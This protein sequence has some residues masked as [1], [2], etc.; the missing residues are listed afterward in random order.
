MQ[1]ADADV[2]GSALHEPAVQVLGFGW[3]PRLQL[4][5]KRVSVRRLDVLLLSV[6]IA[7]LALHATVDSFLAPEPGTGP[8][9]HLVRGFVSLAVLALAAAICTRLPAGGRAAVAAA[10]GLLA[11][12]G[13]ALAIADAR[14]V[15]ARGEDWTG[16]L[17]LPVGLLLCAY[18][19]VLLWRS[20]KP[21]R[22][23]YMRR[24]GIA[25]AAALLAYWL[26]LPLAI[27]ILATHR[28][29]AA[30]EP[31]DLG[32]TYEEVTLRTTDGLEL[33]A[34][35]VASRNGAAVISY[36][37]RRGKLDQA[38]MLARHGYGVLLV[39]ARGYDGSEG[40]P[41]VFGWD[42]AKDINAAVAW[43]RRR[44][45]VRDGRIGGIGFSVGGEMML[46]AAASNPE[47][48][49]VVSEGAGVRSVRDHLLRGPRGLFSLPEA[50]VQTAAVAVMSGSAPPPSLADLVSRIAPR[51]LLLIYAG[52]GG[53][54][55]ELNP[56]YYR[57]AWSP[58][59]LWKIDE[60][61]HVGGF[62]AR[63]QEYEKRVNGF[64]DRAL[65]GLR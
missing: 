49:A 4:T 16:F 18:A 42:G 2:E 29:R 34:W 7:I 50:A 26:V 30:V 57:A 27:G 62:Q 44:P 33:A 36:P 24:A 47:L 3:R 45:D 61:G 11:V 39:D 5:L 13:A 52:R 12:E 20:R 19:F 59:T 17:L 48:R 43:L 8:G 40:D 23:R 21:G 25:V 65:L 15:G 46:Q 6:A 60:A 10:L 38:R 63:P 53:G 9:D 64:F 54:G 58:K 28:P 37:T 22:H 14:A 51:P 56:D 32:R 1:T 35:Y 41:N 55:E 31:A